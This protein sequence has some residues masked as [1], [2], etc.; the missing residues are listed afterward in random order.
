MG[1]AYS[2]D[3]RPFNF[4]IDTR[5]LT[6]LITTCTLNVVGTALE[7]LVNQRSNPALVSLLYLPGVFYS[8]IVDG[9]FFKV[10]PDSSEKLSVV[11]IVSVNAIWFLH[12]YLEEKKS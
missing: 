9:V 3:E 2:N 1:V 8:S 7:V 5:Q 12:K 10:W 6:I 4:E 11:A